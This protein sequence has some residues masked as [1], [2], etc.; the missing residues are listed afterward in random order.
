M[1][2][3]NNPQNYNKFLESH[4]NPFSNPLNGRFNNHNR[5][6]GL[7][8]MFTNPNGPHL[9]SNNINQYNQ[10]QKFTLKNINPN[11]A[12]NQQFFQDIIQIIYTIIL[13]KIIYLIIKYQIKEIIIKYLKIR[14]EFLIMN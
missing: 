5:I 4:N 10:N 1:N 8:N 3:Y 6:N 14:I 13:I 11:N 7:N 9:F 2:D 12:N